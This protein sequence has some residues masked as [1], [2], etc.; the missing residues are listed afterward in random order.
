MLAGLSNVDAEA[1]FQEQANSM[2]SERHDLVA[3]EDPSLLS[4]PRR[5]A[6]GELATSA[7]IPGR[8]VATE[9]E[10]F[11]NES[12]D[13][14]LE[15]DLHKLE[16]E[17]ESISESSAPSTP[18][19]GH[20]LSAAF[21]G[22]LAGLLPDLGVELGDGDGLPRAVEPTS[23]ATSAV[24]AAAVANLPDFSGEFGTDY[25]A[26]YVNDAAAAAT[27]EAAQE[28]QVDDWIQGQKAAQAAH[29]AAVENN[30]PGRPASGS[31]LR[32]ADRAA[33]KL[34]HEDEMLAKARLIA[35]AKN[36]AARRLHAE[37]S[38][39]AAGSATFLKVDRSKT[40]TNLPSTEVDISTPPPAPA[41]PH[42]EEKKSK[43]EKAKKRAAAAAAAGSSKTTPKVVKTGGKVTIANGY[44]PRQ[45][46]LANT[47][48][49]E[50]SEAAAVAAV[51]TAAAALEAAHANLDGSSAYADL[52]VLPVGRS[53]AAVEQG[54][55][56]KGTPS[57]TPTPSFPPSYAS[58]QEV[59][60]AC[61]A[62]QP[63]HEHVQDPFLPPPSESEVKRQLL[64]GSTDD[65]LVHMVPHAKGSVVETA[66]KLAR[67]S[68][69]VTTTPPP[70]PPPASHPPADASFLPS[71]TP[72]PASPASFQSR[73]AAVDGAIK[74]V[75]SSSTGLRVAFSVASEADDEAGT[76]ITSTA[77]DSED[78][79]AQS[80]SPGHRSRPGKSSKRQKGSTRNAT[81]KGNKPAAVLAAA[82]E[83]GRIMGPGSF[84]VTPERGVRG[85]D[86]VQ[87]QQQRHQE[88]RGGG[89]DGTR[90]KLRLD[91]RNFEGF[92]PEPLG[93]GTG[94][95][96]LDQM[97]AELPY[98]RPHMEH[99]FN[100]TEAA[101][102]AA[103][104]FASKFEALQRAGEAYHAAMENIAQSLADDC[105][106]FALPSDTVTSGCEAPLAKYAVTM[107]ELA[108][109]QRKVNAS[110]ARTKQQLESSLQEYEEGA[111]L[112]K[113]YATTH[114]KRFS[115]MSKF[116]TTVEMPQGQESMFKKNHVVAGREAVQAR[117]MCNDATVKWVKQM[118]ALSSS[119]VVGVVEAVRS[120]TAG[121]VEH[122]ERGGG[123]HASL[124]NKDG[125]TAAAKLSTEIQRDVKET[126]LSVNVELAT[127]NELDRAMIDNRVMY[128]G[129]AAS[130]AEQTDAGLQTGGA[131]GTAAA[132]A[133]SAIGYDDIF[134]AVSILGDFPADRP[135]G[136]AD[137]GMPLRKPKRDD[138]REWI[139]SEIAQRVH[140][141]PKQ[142]WLLRREKRFG[143]AKWQWAYCIVRGSTLLAINQEGGEAQQ[144]VA[145]LRAFKFS[146]C[147]P[148]KFNRQYC[149]TLSGKKETLTLQALGPREMME[150]QAGV[151]CDRRSGPVLL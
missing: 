58:D 96:L 62:P 73:N 103:R 134:K 55:A 136:E 66:I 20:G 130:V 32:K 52:V 9:L 76:P 80:A 115:S 140:R 14:T 77:E 85:Y 21:A 57:P 31:A 112:F 24:F 70:P 75:S 106:L 147:P 126:A 37:E 45:A 11:A 101:H 143:I 150:W 54:T 90:R 128:A 35:L 39:A 47:A 135:N 139:S 43:L 59:T 149:F 120:G 102:T 69:Q 95:R 63:L 64:L 146:K 98:F 36:E 44:S 132:E 104:G 107:K 33:A 123:L 121:M 22:S 89:A 74:P 18:E 114:K 133:G 15:E 46:E 72:L 67:A 109:F 23:P 42:H 148:S 26:H 78:A 105:D 122:Y 86:R 91:N 141:A 111:R 34:A 17:L 97:V 41:R 113:D 88:L 50:A 71:G 116:A 1:L 138:L 65:D 29:D 19:K 83:N 61:R 92:S 30:T 129:N 119:T 68:G 13:N 137:D 51:A 151:P 25:G 99:C 142:G 124:Q 16:E 82:F 117:S 84:D 145:D 94:V 4:T 118:T 53:P 49:V 7:T 125:L 5:L 10:A 6:T 110:T 38:G 12:D 144:L 28:A 60:P 40:P 93:T 2:L 87:Q 3:V 79:A 100:E 27:A 81:R 131:A 56:S 108:G 8:V 127:M 48:N